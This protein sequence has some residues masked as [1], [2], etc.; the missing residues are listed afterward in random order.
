MKLSASA[1]VLELGKSLALECSVTGFPIHQVVFRHNQNI[2][3]SISGQAAGGSLESSLPATNRRL[4]HHQHH[5]SNQHRSSSG[6]RRKFG[7]GASS[8]KSGADAGSYFVVD[9][10]AGELTADYGPQK[11]PA[12]LFESSTLPSSEP[13]PAVTSILDDN[14]IIDNVDYHNA[15]DYS[16][17][18]EP[19]ANAGELDFE[20][21]DEI[22]LSHVIVVVL[23]PQHA[24]SYQCFAYNQYESVQSN[25]YIKVLDDPPKFKTKFKEELY[26][27]KQD[28]SLQCSAKANPLP[29]INWF[30][31][32]QPLSDSSR[33][34][35]GDFV[36]KVSV[37]L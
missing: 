18:D 29:E 11:Y 14:S 24:G 15:V 34:K 12:G 36:T 30:L 8:T 31:D 35:I 25:A 22:K 32:G 28:I 16:Y 7:A 6:D 21:E 37:L 26:E 10:G 9:N 4:H 1:N 5:Y 17:D 2:I 3:K 33:V 19:A 23:E 20:K 13:D 27:M